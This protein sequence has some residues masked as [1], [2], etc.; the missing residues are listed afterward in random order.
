MAAPDQL[1][2]AQRLLTCQAPVCSFELSV[3]W[4]VKSSCLNF[5]DRCSQEML[6]GA[7]LVFFVLT[8]DFACFL[9]LSKDLLDRAFSAVAAVSVLRAEEDGSWLTTAF[10]VYVQVYVRKRLSRYNFTA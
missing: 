7:L 9:Q 4:D 5:A 6:S 2:V 3:F 1:A 8:G 10:Q